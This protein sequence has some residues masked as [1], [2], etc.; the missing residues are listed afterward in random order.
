VNGAL[1]VRHLA[2]RWGR[3]AGKSNGR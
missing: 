3:V 2:A 1:T